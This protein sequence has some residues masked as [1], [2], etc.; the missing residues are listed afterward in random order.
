[1][2][3]VAV[4]LGA[5]SLVGFVLAMWFFMDRRQRAARKAV[6]DLDRL[7]MRF[8]RERAKAVELGA[9]SLTAHVDTVID[10]LTRV[11]VAVAEASL[12][13]RGPGARGDRRGLTNK[14]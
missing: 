1:M 8:Q 12:D 11:R 10:S 13:R 9:E 2:G 4:E 6:A 7:I 5:G 14:S 3:W